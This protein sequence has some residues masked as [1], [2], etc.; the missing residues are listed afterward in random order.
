[1]KACRD[2]VGVVRNLSALVC[3]VVLLCACGNKDAKA[4]AVDLPPTPKACAPGIEAGASS[5]IATING[6][7]VPCS[8]LYARDQGVIDAITAKYDEKVLEIHAL[9]LSELVDDKLLQAAADEAKLSVEKF[10]A[11]S[12][13]AVPASDEDVKAFY[14][15]AVDSGEKLPPFEETKADIAGFI[16]EERQKASLSQFRAGLRAKAKIEL[17]LPTQAPAPAAAPASAPAAAPA[18]AP[19]P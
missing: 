12:I 13:T 18:P 8:E 2:S 10:V 4:P 16:T 14:D 19:A 7:A 9:T 17:H 3:L 1:M 15:Q 5:A 6:K 11:S